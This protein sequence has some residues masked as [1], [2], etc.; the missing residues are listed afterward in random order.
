MSGG[1]G[2]FFLLVSLI[3]AIILSLSITFLI[4]RLA[5]IKEILWLEDAKR[6]LRRIKD[7][8]D[9]EDLPVE[10]DDIIALMGLLKGKISTSKVKLEEIQEVAKELNI[11]FMIMRREISQ[12]LKDIGASERIEVR[13]EDEAMSA[14]SIEQFIRKC[15]DDSLSREEILRFPSEKGKKFFILRGEGIT[16]FCMELRERN[17]VLRFLEAKNEFLSLIEK[18]EFRL[19]G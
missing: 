7:R 14:L 11:L 18:I 4:A 10:I 9:A 15:E 3:V 13:T 12:L 5:G 8:I 19:H 16:R 1:V 6:I 2:I 17:S